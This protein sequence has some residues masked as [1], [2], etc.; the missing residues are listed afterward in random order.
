MIP[1][2]VKVVQRLQQIIP[3]SRFSPAYDIYSQVASSGG[4]SPVATQPPPSITQLPRFFGTSSSE[5]LESDTME[6]MILLLLGVNDVE[7]LSK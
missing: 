6:K 4:M 1:T 2:I 7:K 5:I 3:L